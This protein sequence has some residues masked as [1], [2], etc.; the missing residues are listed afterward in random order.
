MRRIGLFATARAKPVCLP[1]ALIMIIAPGA[2]ASEQV[3]EITQSAA[4]RIVARRI[5]PQRNGGDEIHFL[6]GD[7]TEKQ[8]NWLQCPFASPKSNG[9][10][11]LFTFRCVCPFN[12]QTSIALT[13]TFTSILCRCSSLDFT[14]SS[15]RTP[16]VRRA[17]LDATPA[18]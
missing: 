4:A 7:M 13:F 15:S 18:P 1:D 11:C 16:A 5:V 12:A 3:V 14:K 10:E 2:K 8:K 17:F 9:Q 6:V